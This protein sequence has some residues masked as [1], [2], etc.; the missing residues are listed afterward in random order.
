[1]IYGLMIISNDK[2]ESNDD[3]SKTRQ[4]QSKK[5]NFFGVQKICINSTSSDSFDIIFLCLAFNS[6]FFYDFALHKPQ[7]DTNY[8]SKGPPNRILGPGSM[9]NLT[10]KNFL[11]FSLV[12]CPPLMPPPIIGPFGP[13][14]DGVW[15]QW[16]GGGVVTAL[17]SAVSA[18]CSVLTIYSHFDLQTSF[19]PFSHPFSDSH[20][21]WIVQALFICASS[22]LSS[23]LFAYSS[24][25][26]ACPDPNLVL[27]SHFWSKPPLA[28]G[29]LPPPL[30]ILGG[31]GRGVL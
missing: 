25:Q 31:G 8:P 19:W 5:R 18:V 17:S 6:V 12:K 1:M 7:R 3:V 2:R 27:A 23:S 16:T 20:R 13:F 28:F 11:T 24:V 4:F 15:P 22:R 30:G 26:T 29:A 10:Q 9:G 14:W 21:I